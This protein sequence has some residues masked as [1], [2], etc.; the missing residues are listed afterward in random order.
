MKKGNKKDFVRQDSNVLKTWKIIAFCQY[1]PSI[2]Q[3]NKKRAKQSKNARKGA[4]IDL[5]GR[6]YATE[7]EGM[8]RNKRGGIRNK[9]ES[10]RWRKY[11]NK[12]E[13]KKEKE[14][15]REKELKNNVDTDPATK[16][17]LTEYPPTPLI[18]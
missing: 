2:E 11:K 12:K 18:M 5:I 13:R 14:K 7:R 3:L 16:T 15:K 9:M 10:D 6:K 8:S 17:Y 1:L 4:T